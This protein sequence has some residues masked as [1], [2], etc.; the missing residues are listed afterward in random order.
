MLSCTS[1]NTLTRRKWTDFGMGV[2]IGVEHHCGRNTHFRQICFASDAKQKKTRFFKIKKHFFKNKK[3]FK[4]KPSSKKKTIVQKKPSSKKKMLFLMFFYYYLQFKDRK[5]FF[6]T[7]ECLFMLYT[8]CKTLIQ[9]VN[10]IF[11]DSEMNYLMNYN[12]NLHSNIKLH[13]YIL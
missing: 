1:S 3:Q 6:N 2:V 9:Y 7:Q 4:K 8:S 10:C 11:I 13:N 5:V 12:T